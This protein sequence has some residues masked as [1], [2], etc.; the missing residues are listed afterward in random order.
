LPFNEEKYRLGE[1]Y[2]TARRKLHALERRLSMKPEIYEDYR[3][4]LK[5][6]ETLGHMTEAR[7]SNSQEG[8]FLPH[9]AV[10]KESST[11]TK[12]RVVF[13]AS[14][15]TTTGFSL[16]DVLLSGLWYNKISFPS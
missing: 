1:S 3:C 10:L 16:N 8:Y 6:Y 14:S 5:E 9:H 7:Y 11:T 15:K 2:N 13:D 4:F 12:L